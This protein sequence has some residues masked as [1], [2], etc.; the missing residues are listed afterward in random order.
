[1]SIC[2]SGE[3]ARVTLPDNNIQEFTDTPISIATALVIEECQQATVNFTR[4]YSNG[5]QIFFHQ[6]GTVRIYLPYGGITYSKDR[7][8]ILCKNIAATGRY[9][10]AYT[11]Y[12]FGKIGSLGTYY[13]VDFV[14]LEPSNPLYQLTITGNSGNLLFQSTYDNQNYLVECVQ[15]CPPGSFDCGDCCLE[16]EPIRAQISSLRA[17]TNSIN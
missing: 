1:M 4:T 15:G 14:S 17:L 7:L 9:C 16:C 11:Y 12:P 10:A 8:H 6:P 2:S 3:K 5:F 13:G